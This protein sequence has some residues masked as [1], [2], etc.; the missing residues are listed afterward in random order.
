MVIKQQ[1][2][3]FEELLSNSDLPLLVMFYAPWCGSPHL[4]DAT[5]EQINTQMNQQLQIVKISSEDYPDLATRYQIHAL[6]AF[7]LFKS[8]QPV[9]RIETEQTE[10]L[11]PTEHLIQR[12]QPLIEKQS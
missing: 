3:N 7:V 11:I 8:G 12:L 9:E 6:P 1:F 5:L 4:I 2:D 10:D